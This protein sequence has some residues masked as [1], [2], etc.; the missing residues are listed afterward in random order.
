MP[1][2]VAGGAEVWCAAGEA[3]VCDA[4]GEKVVGELPWLERV[5]VA[6][7]VLPPGEAWPGRVLNPA[8]RRLCRLL[9]RGERRLQVFRVGGQRT[10]QGNRVL[11]GHLGARAD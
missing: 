2:T 3:S 10:R 5:V 1:G 11:H 4:A 6:A 9:V 7:E 8:D